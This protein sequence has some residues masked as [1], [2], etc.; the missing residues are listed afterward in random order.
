MKN[1]VLI[2]VVMILIYLFSFDRT[3]LMSAEEGKRGKPLIAAVRPPLR[4]TP[5][6]NA[7]RE[8]APLPRKVVLETA[9][10]PFLQYARVV[11]LANS[12]YTLSCGGST[13]GTFLRHDQEGQLIKSYNRKG[14]GPGEL[15]DPVFLNIAGD[16]LFIS[17]G[18]NPIVHIL[19]PEMNYTGKLSFR[20][21]GQPLFVTDRYLGVWGYN[22]TSTKDE[23]GYMLTLNDRI[24]GR[25]V[26]RLVPV[27]KALFSLALCGGAALFEQKIYAITANTGFIDIID[28]PSLKTTRLDPHDGIYIVAPEPW[29]KWSAKHPEG[30]RIQ[31]VRAWQATFPIP[32]DIGVVRNRLIVLYAKG[33]DYF[34]NVRDLNGALISRNHAVAIPHPMLNGTRLEGIVPTEDDRQWYAF[35]DLNELL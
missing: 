9:E 18:R 24:S 1:L 30:T 23:A 19:D 32:V 6:F 14:H 8:K 4:E 26:K 21:V 25:V 13:R 35:V 22:R 15:S 27:H 29:R 2:F 17:E 31:R 12:L 28:L 33:E 3:D 16:Q 20:G 5:V 34:Y 7:A 10:E 11:S